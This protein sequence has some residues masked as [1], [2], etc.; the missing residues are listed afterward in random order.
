MQNKL[1]FYHK[2]QK[3]D[4]YRSINLETIF[5]EMVYSFFILKLSKY[6]NSEK[7]FKPVRISHNVIEN[8]GNV[9]NK[10]IEVC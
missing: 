10:P 9:E 1:Y 8:I 5:V 6:E 2:S 3:K 7:S 4:G